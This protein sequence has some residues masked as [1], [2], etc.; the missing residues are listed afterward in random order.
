MAEIV[1]LRRARK[2][3]ER[4]RQKAIADQA[5]L[6]HGRSAAERMLAQNERQA[7]RTHLDGH[8][9]ENSD[10]SRDE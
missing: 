5:R 2:A 8:K 3:Q 9:M 7:T 1:N 6:K 10:E 4:M